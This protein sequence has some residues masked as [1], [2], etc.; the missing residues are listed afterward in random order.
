M[1]KLEQLRGAAVKMFGEEWARNADDATADRFQSG[2]DREPVCRYETTDEYLIAIGQVG[3]VVAMPLYLANE[4]FPRL[5]AL[6]AARPATLA[7][8]RAEAEPVQDEADEYLDSL[9]CERCGRPG[10]QELPDHGFSR[11]LCERCAT[12]AVASGELSGF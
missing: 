12:A 3:E 7:E 1:T 5:V 2:I 11:Q 9:P 4:R 8:V 10:A 6:A